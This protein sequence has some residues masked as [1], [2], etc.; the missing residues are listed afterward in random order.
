MRP[1][2]NSAKP[3]RGI[4][5]PHK[6]KL[7]IAV[8]SQNS[9]KPERGIETVNRFLAILKK[10]GQNSAKPERGIETAIIAGI[11]LLLMLSEQR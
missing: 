6:Q 4:E 5:T 3:E 11:D 1:C 8:I 10:Q 9:A 7:A 2:Q